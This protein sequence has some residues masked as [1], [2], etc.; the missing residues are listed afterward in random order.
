MRARPGSAVLERAGLERTGLQP[1]QVPQTIGLCADRLGDV[2]DVR[3]RQDQLGAGI[4]DDGAQPRER[5]VDSP[6]I[7]RI[8]RHSDDAGV[9]TPQEGRDEVDAALVQQEGPSPGTKRC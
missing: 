2:K 3:A 9:E 8:C 4:V 7:R 1:D 6:Q 5:A